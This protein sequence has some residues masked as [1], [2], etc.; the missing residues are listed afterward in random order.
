[1]QD[2]LDLLLDGNESEI[3]ELDSDDDDDDDD[4][5][6]GDF[7]CHD[8][9]FFDEEVDEH[10][11]VGR[12]D[13]EHDNND[14][15]DD[16]NDA[17]RSKDSLPCSMNQP[18]SSPLK[19]HTFRWRTRDI[20]SVTKAFVPHH[21]NITH[22][23]TPFEYFKLF[24][25]DELN[26]LIAEQTNLYSMH[27]TGDSI[28]T[29]KDEIQKYVGIHLRMGVVQLPSYRMYWSQNMRCP[30]IADVMPLKR[31]D[32]LKRFIHFVD[33]SKYEESNSDKLF[34]IRPVIEKVRA[35]CLRVLPEEM[36]SID[37]Q[38]IPA[39]TTYSGIRQYNPKKPK[40]WGFKNLVRAGASGMMYDFYIYTGKGEQV[41]TAPE[42]EHLQ[43]SAQVVARLCQHLPV[44]ASHKL[45]FDNWFTTL[46]LLIYLKKRGI[47]SCGT[48]RAN[49]LQ[50]CP[51]LSNKEL[52][53]KGRGSLDYKSDLNSGVIVAKWM[54]N[55]SVHV[56]S[57][58]V[59]VEPVGKVKRWSGVDKCKK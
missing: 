13:E 54:D 28:K 23:G 39:K 21:E 1:M 19:K 26:E 43:K 59:G 50:R 15:D 58:F 49:R 18:P 42:F 17:G 11:K 29:D 24:W 3:G 35:Q 57:N 12:G 44:N 7:E 33:N 16:D 8:A 47:L 31:F 10:D 51:L 27:K 40:K 37:E 48:V 34:K 2:A 6:I 20:P 30:Q 36:H 38:I 52:Q 55:S 22:L 32:K 45:F 14:V 9:G 25:R 5:D 46:D 53:K 56:A 41:E 4:D